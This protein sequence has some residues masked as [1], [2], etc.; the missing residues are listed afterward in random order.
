MVR[1]IDDHR[2]AY[3]IESICAVVPIA[4][5]TYFRQQ[6]AA[7]GSDASAGAGAARRR[8]ARGDSAGLGRATSRCTG[9]GR[10]G[11]SCGAKA[12]RVA[13]CTVER[14]MRDDG[15]AWRGA[16]PRVG[17]HHA[18]ATRPPTGR[19]ISSI[20][21]LSRR[22]RI[23]SGSPTSPTSRPGAAS[24]TSPSSST[25]SR[26]A[27][28]A[29]ASRRRC[30]PTSS[31][32]RSSRRST[33]GAAPASTDLVHHSDRG[34]QYLSMRYTDRLADAGID[35][36]R[37]QP[38]RFVRQRPRRIGHRPLQDGGDST[39]GTVA[40]SRGRRIRHAR[41][42][43]TGSTRADCSNRLATCRRRNMKRA[44]MSSCASPPRSKTTSPRGYQSLHRPTIV[45]PGA[46]YEVEL[47][48]ID[49][50]FSVVA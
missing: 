4:P 32:M 17:D 7:G 20:A 28:S 11:G 1:F 24:S 3:G 34:T 50:E 2:D 36:V 41:R 10:C 19:P 43:S 49:A 14:L 35:A 40:A 12:I 26:A 5:S 30:G 25:S 27:S 31:S 47:P 39:E 46:S 6:G 37:R 9:R 42:G 29:G 23:S 22:G 16:R 21:T 8:A 38:R 48:S 33:T 44:T 15:P 45:A 13:R 18:V